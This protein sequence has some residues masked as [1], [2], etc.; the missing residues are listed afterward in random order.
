[1][2]LAVV[3]PP[4]TEPVTV[5]EAKAFLRLDG[6]DDDGLIGGLIVAARRWCEDY[7]GRTFVTTV[8]DWSFDCFGGPVLYMPRPTVQSVASITYLDKAGVTQTLAPTVYR[9]DT[10]SEIGRIAL[11]YG[12]VWPPTLPE[13][14]AVTARFTAGYTA[15][16]EHVKQA[17]LLLTGELYEQRQQSVQGVV[18]SVPFGVRELLATEKIWHV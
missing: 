18:S 3:T 13:I 6:G 12:Q 15:V 9:V 11:G 2:G 1:M 5:A 17:I 10:A 14:N 4:T 8:F 7:T 16:P